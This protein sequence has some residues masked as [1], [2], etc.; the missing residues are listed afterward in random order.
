MLAW[1][2]W[3]TVAAN[4]RLSRPTNCHPLTVAHLEAGPT[5]AANQWLSRPTNGHPLAVACW[6]RGSTVGAPTAE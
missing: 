4:Q 5:V 1:S 6:G 3:P 2:E